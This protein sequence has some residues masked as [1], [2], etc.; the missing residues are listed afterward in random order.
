MDS[1]VIDR[2]QKPSDCIID[3]MLIAITHATL[4]PIRCFLVI[5]IA[6]QGN[7]SIPEKYAVETCCDRTVKSRVLTI[8][9]ERSMEK[10]KVTDM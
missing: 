3:S 7:T 9:E 4:K 8:A 5:L 1:F 10:I 2:K 6:Y